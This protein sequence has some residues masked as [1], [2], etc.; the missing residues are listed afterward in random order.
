MQL[1][2]MTPQ[3]IAA[4]KEK[5]MH[6]LPQT[7]DAIFA[8]PIDWVMFDAAQ[9]QL[10]PRLTSFVDKKITEMLGEQEESLVRPHFCQSSVH[11]LVYSCLCISLIVV[12]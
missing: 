8:A 5:V 1:P 11:F 9:K 12:L 6:A 4:G 10:L 2:E 3:E 7:R